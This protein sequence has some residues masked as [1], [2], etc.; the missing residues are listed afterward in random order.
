M[1][2]EAFAGEVHRAYLELHRQGI[3]PTARLVLAAIPQPQYRSLD[4]V[5]EIMRRAR[6]ELSI[7]PWYPSSRV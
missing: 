4:L 1:K 5:A 3:Y 2:R 7:K 6:H